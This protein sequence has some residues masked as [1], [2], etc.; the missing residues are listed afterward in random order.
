LWNND[1]LGQIR[2]DMVM[3]GIQ[4]NAVTLKNPDFG[5]IAQAYG[6]AYAKPGRLE[7]LPA[8]IKAALAADRPTLIEMTPRM[9]KG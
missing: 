7:D 5:P 3:K 1:A 4:P 2:D 9:L 8:A 6:C